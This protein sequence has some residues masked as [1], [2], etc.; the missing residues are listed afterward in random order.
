MVSLFLSF[1]L[2][3]WNVQLLSP[4]LFAHPAPPRV[5][6][7]GG[8][9]S[10]CRLDSTVEHPCRPF[11]RVLP[12]R[13]F[14]CTLRPPPHHR[15][16]Q[17][18]RRDQKGHYFRSHIHRLQRWQHRRR[19]PRLQRGETGEIQIDL[20]ISHRG[21]GVCLAGQSLPEVVL[22]QSECEAGCRSRSWSWG[23]DRWGY[24]GE[25]GIGRDAGVGAIRTI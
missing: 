25:A 8:D 4:L 3:Q 1:T 9:R 23:G 5:L 2:H 18:P 19:V 20:D 13:L 10:H 15:R 21:H 22:H 7:T 17:H 12:R 16:I 6:H 14:R 11:D 24:S